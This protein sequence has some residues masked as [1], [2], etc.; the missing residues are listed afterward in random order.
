MAPIYSVI[1]L[2]TLALAVEASECWTSIRNDT[3]ACYNSAPITFNFDLKTATDCRNWCGEIEKCQSWTYVE[4]SN[5]CDLYRTAALSISNNTGFTFG[6]C[7]PVG[8]PS[9]NSFTPSPFSISATST[10]STHVEIETGHLS[11]AVRG[12]GHGYGRKHGHG[13]H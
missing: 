2:A 10:A 7:D 4:Y 8:T 12:V 13:H 1:A 11:R 6:G 3:I 9:V 5:Q